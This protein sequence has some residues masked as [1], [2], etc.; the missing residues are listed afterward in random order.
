M[1]WVN[2]ATFFSDTIPCLTIGDENWSMTKA[3]WL[4][5][6]SPKHCNYLPR[7]RPGDAI[8]TPV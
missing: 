7:I 5:D 2:N 6:T 3:P 1:A 4:V 8:A